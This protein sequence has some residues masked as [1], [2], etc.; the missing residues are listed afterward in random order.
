M[1]LLAN[2]VLFSWSGVNILFGT[3]R[4]FRLFT[5][6]DR[7]KSVTEGPTGQLWTPKKNTGSRGKVRAVDSTGLWI[8]VK[9]SFRLRVEETSLLDRSQKR[10]SKCWELNLRYVAMGCM[11]QCVHNSG[12]VR[13]R[14]TLAEANLRV[15]TII[16]TQENF[17]ELALHITWI[18]ILGILTVI[19]LSAKP[20][21]FS[22]A[23]QRKHCPLQCC[24]DRAAQCQ[25]N[26]G[27]YPLTFTLDDK[28]IFQTQSAVLGEDYGAMHI[29]FTTW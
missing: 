9:C 6:D 25:R 17:P 8:K 11:A 28:N 15:Q 4:N 1:V 29:K 18:Y 23:S 16:V 3:W 26:K 10:F 20:V 27:S 5:F 12:C 24:S 22:L 2:T 21:R 19:L 14:T 7:L 13:A